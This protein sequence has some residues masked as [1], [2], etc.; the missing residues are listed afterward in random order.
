M[1]NKK[2]LILMLAVFL[3]GFA[4]PV[5]AENLQGWGKTKWGMT[6]EEL[7]ALLPE[8]IEKIGGNTIFLKQI[9]VGNLKV[10]VRLLLEDDKL[11]KVMLDEE[12]GGK[13]PDD[14][15]DFKGLLTQKYGEPATKKEKRMK[16]TGWLLSTTTSWFLGGTRID[17]NCIGAAVLAVYTPLENTDNL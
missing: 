12:I 15:N 8:K 17:L 16:K 3:L 9:N 1:I 5:H 11:V 2:N 4:L 6:S 7:K 10:G 13:E 14:C